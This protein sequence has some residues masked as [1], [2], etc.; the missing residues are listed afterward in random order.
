MAN[1]WKISCLLAISSMTL[2]ACV[3]FA[4]KKDAVELPDIPEPEPS[5]CLSAEEV[6]QWGH[7]YTHK[8]ALKNPPQLINEA[9]A[10]C[11]RT[12]FQKKLATTHG[13]LAGYKVALTNAEV[14][15]NFDITEPI[16]GT[17]YANMLPNRKGKIIIDTQYGVH[18]IYQASLMVRVKSAAINK[19]KTPEDV[20]KHID[21]IVPFV[22]LAD[23]AVQKPSELTAYGFMAINTGAR[24]G[25]LGRPLKVSKSASRRKRML[26][27]LQSMSV[28]VIGEGGQLLGHGAGKDTLGHPLQPIL[29]LIPK[30]QAQGLELK[31][32]QWVSV[33]AFSPMLRPQAGQKVTVAYPGLTGARSLVLYFQ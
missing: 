1:R 15:K 20:L 10:Q 18:P 30:L 24:T 11:T 8:I 13:K 27:Q 26:R 14:Q 19:A 23:V 9:D 2:S 28:R 3:V 22:E 16:W 5:R 6:A 32:K 12:L 33:G 25:V 21:Q 29:W 4:P 17:Y 31:P 7:N